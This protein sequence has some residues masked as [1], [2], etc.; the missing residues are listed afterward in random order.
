MSSK[1]V[2]YPSTAGIAPTAIIHPNVRFGRDVIVEDYCIIGHPHKGDSL[3]ELETVI[4]DGT[5]IRS[6]SVVYAGVSI[7][8]GCKIAHGS[9]IREYTTIGDWTS[10]GLNVVIEHH[11]LIGNGVRIQGQAGLAEHTIVEDDAWIGPRVVTANVFH[12]TCERAKECLAGPIIRRGAI[13]GGHAFIAPDI[14]IGANSFVAAGSVVTKSVDEGTIVFGVPAKKI[15]TTDKMRCQYDMVTG[16]PYAANRP[17]HLDQ[18]VPLVD[19]AAQHQ[20]LKQEIRL[21]IDR[22][23]LNTRFISG[24]EV[25]EFEAAFATYCGAS[26]AVGVSSGT[27]ALELAL[28]GLGVGPGD[29]VITQP[30]T[31]IATAEAI[32]AVGAKPVFV[33]V[34]QGSGEID[35]A[36]IE[37]AI[38]CRAKAILPVHLYGK[39]AQMDVICRMAAE[40]GLLV[41]EDAAQA[42]GAAR[43]GRRAGTWGNAACFSF[44]PGKNLGAY[45]DAGAVVTS[46]GP[47]ATRLR[48]LRDHGRAEKYVSDVLGGNHRLDTIQAA[49]L[50][51]KLRHLE[52]WNEA[53]KRHAQAYREG[54]CD[55]PLMLP[56]AGGAEEHV[57]HLF[58]VQTDR[59]DQLKEFL[60]ERGISTGI[61]YPVAL[62][63]QPALHDLGHRGGDMPVAERL[64]KTS[65]SLPMYPEMNEAKLLAVVDGVRAFFGLQ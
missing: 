6:H 32:L 47:L 51:V 64:A 35:P 18:I 63:L 40:H 15:G 8:T 37:S 13:I 44:Y 24:K 38:T 26:E 9:F 11:C 23:I 31:F 16:S 19:L 59:R 57:Y 62:H 17:K 22:V 48:K 55:L 39:L 27:S 50:N 58:V 4:G 43:Q 60:H 7:G 33:D 25:A 49:I 2:D 21:A 42:H 61:H 28:R 46:D 10:I 1:L 56:A 36:A 29:E 20:S 41:I 65:L 52:K 14:E 45:G 30:N 5:V 12:P 53:R 3:G 34:L 54:L